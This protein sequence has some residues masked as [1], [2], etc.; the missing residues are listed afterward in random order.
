MSTS[1]VNGYFK[2][3]QDYYVA[4]ADRAH[5]S[6]QMTNA[7]GADPVVDAVELSPPVDPSGRAFCYLDTLTQSDKAFVKGATGWDIDD[8][9]L[10]ATASP[11]AKAFVGRLTMDRYTFEKYGSSDG[12][13]GQIDQ[14]YIQHMIQEQLDGQGMVPLSILY[15]AQSYLT[16]QRNPV[17][18]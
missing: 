2:Q 3:L 6:A 16:Q 13:T 17:Q 15:K 8:D 9:P 12:F 7:S 5:H 10:G 14:A 11:E 18:P 1:P 4:K